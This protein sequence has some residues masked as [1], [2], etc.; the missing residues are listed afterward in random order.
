LEKVEVL[1]IAAPAPLKDVDHVTI[2]PEEAKKQQ[3]GYQGWVN[4]TRGQAMKRVNSEDPEER[5]R[6]LYRL[7]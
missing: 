5:I 4:W 7:G 3:T 6:G 1:N 2:N